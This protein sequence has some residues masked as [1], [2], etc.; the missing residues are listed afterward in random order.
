MVMG[1]GENGGIRDIGT[2]VAVRSGTGE[3]QGRVVWEGR[4]LWTRRS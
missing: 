3:E 1:S 2:S 4:R